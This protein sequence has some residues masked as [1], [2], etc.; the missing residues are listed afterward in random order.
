MRHEA[1]TARAA[2]QRRR[3]PVTIGIVLAAGLAVTG[4]GQQTSVGA[5]ADTPTASTSTDGDTVTKS[6]EQSRVVRLDAGDERPRLVCPSDERSMMI[7][8]FAVGARGA[9]TPQKAVGLSSLEAGERMVVS[10]PGTRVWIVR[11]DGTAREENHL[12]HL[13]GWLLHMRETCA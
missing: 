3:V 12:T 5:A 6:P 8:D 2:E 7:A 1:A 11:P 9:A 4:C 13:R 10:P